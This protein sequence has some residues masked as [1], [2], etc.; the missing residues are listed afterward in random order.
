MEI[1]EKI[2]TKKQ[3]IFELANTLQITERKADMLFDIFFNLIIKELLKG[4]KVVFRDFGTFYLHILKPQTKTMPNHTKVETKKSIIVRFRSS[5][6]LRE[7]L[8]NRYNQLIIDK[9][10]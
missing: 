9:E 10:N 4:K 1:F 2:F 8:T 7:K 3:F 6:I 5:K